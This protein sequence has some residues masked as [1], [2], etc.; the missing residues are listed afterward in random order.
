MGYLV[1]CVPPAPLLLIF[2]FKHFILF[3]HFL[4]HLHLL[5]AQTPCVCGYICLFWSKPPN[6]WTTRYQRRER[7]N[8]EKN[9]K[10]G[11]QT[12]NSNLQRTFT[13]KIFQYRQVKMMSKS[14]VSIFTFIKELYN[15]I[16]VQIPAPISKGCLVQASTW[17]KGLNMSRGPW[18]LS[19]LA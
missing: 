8:S 1:V 16:I 12:I 10:D 14:L 4:V 6:H 19:W 11:E 18:G 2:G 9:P 15:S 3:T 5:C 7:E 13:R 17:G